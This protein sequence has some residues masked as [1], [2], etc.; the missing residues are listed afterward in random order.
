MSQN[1]ASEGYATVMSIDV[2]SGAVKEM[3]SEKWY[4]LGRV[5]WL[6]DGSGLIITAIGHAGEHYQIWQLS[7][8]SGEVKRITNDVSDYQSVSLSVANDSKTI[9][10]VLNDFVSSVWITPVDSATERP[11]Q[12]TADTSSLD[13]SHGLVWTPDGRFIWSSM[14]GGNWNIWSMNA[15][16]SNR[17][18]LTTEVD[19]DRF[20]VVSPDGRYVVFESRRGGGVPAIWRMDIDGGNLKQLTKVP[21]FNPRCTPDGSWV[22]HWT[23]D[24]NAIDY[25]SSE[26]GSANIWSQPLSGGKPIRLTDFKAPYIFG[27]DIS[28]DGKQIA[29]A[30]GRLPTD[31]VL[32]S[33]FR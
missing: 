8:P 13:G 12:I 17:K 5:A 16:G 26:G 7:Y 2:Q 20:P 31:V 28:R 21:S 10:S 18:Q 33:N 1:G 14:A 15:D 29:C 23:P 6:A 22:F 11:R 30:L 25:V 27:F 3:T 24:G 9:A 4:I 32:I 19:G